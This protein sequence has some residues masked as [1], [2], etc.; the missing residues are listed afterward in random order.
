M[1]WPEAFY[2][3]LW[4]STFYEIFISWEISQAASDVEPV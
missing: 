3:D 4:I 2:L 1:L